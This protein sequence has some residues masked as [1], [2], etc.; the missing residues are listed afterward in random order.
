MSMKLLGGAKGLVCVKHVSRELLP[1]LEEHFEEY[2]ST[3][4]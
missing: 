2:S 3:G 4:P 1:S